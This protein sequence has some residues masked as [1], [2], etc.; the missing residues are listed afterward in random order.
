MKMKK[1]NQALTILGGIGAG[2]ALMYFLDPERG[3][4]RRDSVKEKATELSNDVKNNVTGYTNDFKDKAAE[5]Y[6]GAKPYVNRG[7][8]K[9]SETAGQLASAATTATEKAADAVSDK[10]NGNPFGNQ[11]RTFGSSN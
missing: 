6:D 7:T 3:R 10:T 4:T 1:T 11:A 8:E 2:A 9:A 5:L